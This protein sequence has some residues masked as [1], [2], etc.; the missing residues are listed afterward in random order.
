[1]A[2]RLGSEHA[3]FFSSQQ[4]SISSSLLSVA[5]MTDSVAGIPPYSRKAVR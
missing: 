5:H 1:M 4:H 3:A 2:V